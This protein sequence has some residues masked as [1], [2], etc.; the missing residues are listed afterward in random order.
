MYKMAASRLFKT[1]YLECDG[2]GSD[3]IWERRMHPTRLCAYVKTI[4]VVRPRGQ[5]WGF[6][7][8]HFPRAFVDCLYHLFKVAE[9]L[10]NVW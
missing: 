3:R 5:F 6:R 9:N 7:W 1:L 2:F 4:I 10:Q 8:T